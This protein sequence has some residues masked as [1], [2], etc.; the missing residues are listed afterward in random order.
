MSLVY[1]HWRRERCLKSNSC[2]SLTHTNLLVKIFSLHDTVCLDI[3]GITTSTPF[4]YGGGV[5]T[6]DGSYLAEFCGA[7]AIKN[8]SFK[9]S[10][11]PPTINEVIFNSTKKLL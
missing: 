10:A 2:A 4:Q 5:Q 3:I 6:H 7:S 9:R 8:S 11:R 1:V